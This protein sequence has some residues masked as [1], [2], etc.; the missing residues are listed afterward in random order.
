MVILG[1]CWPKHAAAPGPSAMYTYTRRGCTSLVE[2]M[3]QPAR[4]R[5]N[6]SVSSD[7][8]GIEESLVF[9]SIFGIVW[10]VWE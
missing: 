9:L 2:V 4:Y 3:F 10:V 1:R 8:R 6:V 5:G 7:R